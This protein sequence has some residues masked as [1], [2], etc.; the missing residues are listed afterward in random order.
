MVKKT[1]NAKAK[2]SFQPPLETRKVDF[3]YSKAYKPAKKDKTNRNNQ[4][5]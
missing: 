2:T 4:N 1:I 5:N 3:S